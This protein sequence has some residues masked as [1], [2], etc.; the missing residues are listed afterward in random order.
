MLWI[1]W[2]VLA[3]LLSKKPQSLEYEKFGLSL[4]LARKRVAS[5]VELLK[6]ETGILIS[7]LD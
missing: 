4:D 1:S 3:A 5:S 7:F 2:E 6:W